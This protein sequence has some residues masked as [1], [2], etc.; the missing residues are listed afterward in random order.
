VI[1]LVINCGSSPLKF[2]VIEGEPATLTEGEP[3][4]RARGIVDRLG[5]DATLRFEL[6]GAPPLLRTDPVPHHEAAVRRTLEWVAGA[7]GV[8]RIDAVGHR[9]VHGG[10]RFR[11]SVVLDEEVETTIEGLGDLAPLHNEASVAGIKACRRLLGPGVPMVA[12]FDTAFHATL[13]EHALRYAIP[14]ELSLRYGVRRYGFHGTSY[15]SVLARYGRLTGTPASQASLVALHLGNGCSAAA[16]ER[17]RS[18][19]TSMGFTPLEGL[20][21][22]TRSGDLDPAVVAYLARKARV[23]VAEVDRWLNERSDLR[24]MAGTRDMRALLDREPHDARA[25]L[26]VDMFCY[27]ARKYVG[28][29]LTVLGG[30]GGSCSRAASGRTR[31]PSARGSR[32]ASTASASRSIPSGT[33][34]PSGGRRPSTPGPRGCRRG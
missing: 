28:A 34:G 32:E 18:V 25:R 3:R 11:R 1:I 12:V 27:R 15:R 5:E 17:G 4:R 10:E 26:A 16:I 19:D 21:M 22:G 33:P 8:P 6:A 9:V 2:Q 13:P 20:V 23:P 14:Y 7:A 30:A 31:R 29:Y 24:G